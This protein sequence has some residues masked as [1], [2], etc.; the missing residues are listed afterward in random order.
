MGVRTDLLGNGIGRC[1]VDQVLRVATDL[2]THSTFRLLVVDAENPELVPYY[3]KYG[4]RPLTNDLRM[5]MKMSA[6]RKIVTGLA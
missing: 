2:H 5:V 3:E 1:V 6:V 4:F